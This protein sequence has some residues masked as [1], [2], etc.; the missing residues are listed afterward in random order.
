MGCGDKG[1]RNSTA[2]APPQGIYRAI[3]WPVLQILKPSPGGKNEQFAAH[4]HRDPWMAETRGWSCCLPITPPLTN[5]KNIHGLH[6]LWTTNIK[7]LIYSVQTGHTVLR[8][9]TCCGPFCLAKQYSC[10]FLLHPKLCL[11]DI[12]VI[13]C[14]GTEAGFGFSWVSTSGVSVPH[15]Q[16]P[17]S[18]YLS[19]TH[20]P[21]PI[22][23]PRPGTLSPFRSSGF[24][25]V[26]APEGREWAAV[27]K[28]DHDG[29]GEWREEPWMFRMTFPHIRHKS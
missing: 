2:W 5:Q 16:C 7:L 15:P 3:L 13:W 11:W 10:S 14:Q 4:K 1:E 20:L 6:P 12:S 27:G 29:D 23:H 21:Y 22:V 26:Q 25:S 17:F 18:I 19:Q 28:L 8:T 9:L 24:L